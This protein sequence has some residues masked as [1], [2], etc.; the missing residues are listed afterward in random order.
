MTDDVE[1]IEIMLPTLNQTVKL[2][3][4]ASA[5][6]WAAVK[7]GEASSPEEYLIQAL[8][9]LVT[10]PETDISTLENADKGSKASVT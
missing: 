10:T 6:I 9:R 4:E 7:R 3:R 2:S 1:M 8:K 5:N